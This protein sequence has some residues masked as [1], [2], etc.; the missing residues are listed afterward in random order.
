MLRLRPDFHALKD[1]NSFERKLKE[2]KYF[3]G[4]KV[5]YLIEQDEK[6]LEKERKK[7]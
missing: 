5:D 7:E 3:S 2:E 6:T 4:C 1:Q